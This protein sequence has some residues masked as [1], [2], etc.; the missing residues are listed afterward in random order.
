MTFSS[1]SKVQVAACA[2]ALLSFWDGCY[3]IMVNQKRVTFCG[4]HD[5]PVLCSKYVIRIPF[6]CFR[7]NILRVKHVI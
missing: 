6:N 4:C 1:L 5:R 2:I 3:V 7:W